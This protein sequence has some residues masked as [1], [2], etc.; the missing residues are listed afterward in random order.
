M[1]SRK[2]VVLLVSA[3]V[4]LSAWGSVG[5]SISGIITDS[6]GSVVPNANVAL[7]NTDTGVRQAV[8][9]NDRGAYSL[10]AVPVGRY[11]IEISVP[12][13]EGYERTGITINTNDQLIIDV[14]LKVG[15]VNQ[16][17]AVSADSVH[18]ETASTQLGDVI[19][20]RQMEIL[21]LN[22]RQYT[23]LLG[24]QPGVAPGASTQTAGYSQYFGTTETGSISVSGQRE[25]S[26]G[27][28]VNG[29][30]VNDLLN[31]GTTVVPN[32]DSIAEF[33]ILTSNFDAEYGNYSGGLVSVVT[34]SG[35]N[36][37]HGDL[38]DYF[39]NTSLDARSYF[40][41]QKNAFQQNQFG[42]TI[43]GPIRRD[44]VFFFADYQGTRS[45]I[46][47][48]GG[49]IPVPSSAD[50]SGNLADLSSSLTGAVSGSYWANLLSNELGY[51]VSAGE[52][53]YT[54]GCTSPTN[55]V[56]PNAIIPQSAISAPAAALMKYI[57][58]ANQPEGLF[59]SNQ[60][61]VRTTDDL[62]S[63]RADFNTK[64][65][66]VITGYYFFDNIFILT[67][68]GGNNLPGFPSQNGGRSQLYILSD[69]KVFNASTLNELHLTYN[70]HVYHNGKPTSGFGSLSSF[71]FNENQPG[72]IVSTAGNQEGVPTISFNSY[73]IGNPIVAYNRYENAPQVADNFS[74]VF[75]S[76]SLKFGGQY[77]FNELAEPMP[78]VVANGAFGFNG[79][80][81]GSDFADF[82]AGAP[83]SFSQAGGFYYDNRRNYFGLFGQDSWRAM[84]NLA[85]NYGLRWDVVLPWYEKRNQVAAFVAGAQSTVFPEAPLGYVFPGDTV[86]GYGKIPRGIA[87][88]QYHNLAPRI[89]FA[90]TPSA[91]G[92]LG[93]FLGADK[94]SARG[95]WGLFYQNGE[96]EQALD[97]TAEA[98]FDVFYGAVLPPVFA[99]P[100][101]N[102]FDGGIHA[103]FPFSPTNFVWA[104]ALPLSSYPSVPITQKVP[105][106]ESYNLTLQRQFGASTVV[107]VGYLGNQGHR[108][109]SQF[110]N[111]PGNPQLC[112]SLSEQE[113]VAPGS[114]TCGPFL[115]NL[116]FTQT[117]GTVVNS[118]RQPF[119]GNFG[120]NYSFESN[121]GSSYNSLQLSVRH[122]T[123]RL[124]VFAGYTY[125][126]SMDNTSNLQDK[127]PNP[128]NP[129]VS[130][131][132]SSF[133]V[134]HNFVVSYSYVLPFDRLVDGRDN[135]LTSGWSVV[136]ITH[137]ATGFPIVMG[138][139]DDHSLLGNT[140][141]ADTPD[142]LGG[143]L[144]FQNPRKANVTTG[145]PYFNTAL[146]AP[147]AI[148]Q[149]G[150]ANRAFFHGPGF[151][152]FDMSLL[153]DTK[154]TERSSLQVRAEFFNVFNHA[155]FTNPSG[156]ITA[157][158]S[159]FG[160][161][162]SAQPGRIGQL[163]LKILF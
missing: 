110:A 25:T 155:Q 46:G 101:T 68:F 67:P 147:S 57:P 152:R 134:T 135:R 61:T 161:I 6:T 81:T 24:L 100:Y 71:G 53:Y 113:N 77:M 108:L 73:S 157:G 158:P 94:F 122:T 79:T 8:T 137:L 13:F 76:H 83:T 72:G 162:N 151:N 82:L 51:P 105:Y 45:N 1:L 163:A 85:L 119:G 3:L 141:G 37:F 109:L 35:T 50:R 120:D 39:R 15:G 19:A 40:D 23:D 132:L 148:G 54:P 130:Y 95:G 140:L 102:R 118:T 70:R 88:T 143:N 49:Q 33:R 104:N 5:G 4:A 139:T 156:N 138:E 10:L 131:G 34:K 123:P 136:G 44:K 22:G 92:A 62:F 64:N 150:S 126:K 27:F 91:D 149:E 30:V 103:P 32:L 107:S 106:V 145:V 16:S 42:G 124:Y 97:Q 112:L 28:M 160:I 115:E 59:A 80:E 111:N 144:N 11:Q 29:S 75:G 121:T 56:F 142:F 90:W 87:R 60:N 21:P 66:G 74:K 52:S 38:F 20:G 18:V 58:A 93:H 47:Q 125:S 17:V 96:G 41:V 12:G 48:E 86:A 14:I 78:L 116:V 98:P 146:F 159:A 153:K 43:G 63:G 55:C 65:F 26:N 9:T 127:T 31:N 128:L 99:S 2:I 117:D 133:D 89:G 129:A 36:E 154:L 69:T 7:T 114:P 84:R